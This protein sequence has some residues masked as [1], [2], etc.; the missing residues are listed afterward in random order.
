[1]IPDISDLF[2]RKALGSKN[3]VLV[4][5]TTPESLESEMVSRIKESLEEKLEK[6]VVLDSKVDP[7]IIGGMILRVGNTVIDGSVRGKLARMR[8]ELL[9]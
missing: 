4:I 9:T 7:S 2:D 6:D 3:K 8:K 1:M 5:A